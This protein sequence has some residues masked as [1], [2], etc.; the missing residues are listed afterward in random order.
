M[1]LHVR[2]KNGKMKNRVENNENMC[3]LKGVNRK[4]GILNLFQGM[5]AYKVEVHT[6]G[7]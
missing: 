6:S 7:L 1:F 2:W 5:R 4:A 3:S